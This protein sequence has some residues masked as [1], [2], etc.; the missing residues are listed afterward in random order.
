MQ[1]TKAV[2]NPDSNKDFRKRWRYLVYKSS[3]C[4]F[5]P[6]IEW[7]FN[8]IKMHWRYTI[9]LIDAISLDALS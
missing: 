2:V 5:S 1:A 4:V 3:N 6:E 7:K 8:R 9:G